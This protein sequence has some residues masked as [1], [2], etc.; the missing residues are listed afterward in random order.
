MQCLG[1]FQKGLRV[2]AVLNSITPH[3][4]SVLILELPVHVRTI[5]VGECRPM[6]E[7]TGSGFS[8]LRILP[9]A[10]IS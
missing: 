5:R 3:T 10:T 1:A 7:R 4:G 9:T 8:Q 2:V 6:P